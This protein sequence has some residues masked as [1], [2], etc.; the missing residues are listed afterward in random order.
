MPRIPLRRNRA[1]T[2]VELL[3]VI[4]I[5]GILIALLL[6]AVQAA[7]EAARRMQCTNNLKQLVLACHNFEGA[8]GG[9]PKIYTSSSQPGWMTAVLPYIEQG[10]LSTLWPGGLDPNG[11]NWKD[12]SLKT[13]V[14]TVLQVQ[15]CPSSPEGGQ[16]ITLTDGGTTYTAATADYAAANGFNSTLY[17]QLRPPGISDVSS[18]MQVGKFGKLAG[19]TDGT[20]HTILLVEMSG[21]PYWYLPGGRRSTS[22]S[23]NPKTYG[24]GFWAHNNAHTISTYTADGLTRGTQCAINC[25]N[26]YAIYS[27]HPGGANVGF[28]DG[29]VHMLSESVSPLV[30]SGLVTRGGGEVVNSDAY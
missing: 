24:Y 5:I 29:S 11:T 30:L 27:F 18:P 3:V 2:L 25:S 15:T 14:S 13:V 12:L 10:N 23:N 26:Q 1:F 9:L 6:P 19:V 22:T 8:R 17:P 16:A 28:T 4:A 21:R 7:R 20:S